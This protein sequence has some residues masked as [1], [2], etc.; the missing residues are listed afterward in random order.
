MDSKEAVWRAQTSLPNSK[1]GL[2][3]ETNSNLWADTSIT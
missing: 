2:S 1:E 3:I